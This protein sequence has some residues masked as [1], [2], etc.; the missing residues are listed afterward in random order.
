VQVSPGEAGSRG[1][2]RYLRDPRSPRCARGSSAV[3]SVGVSVSLTRHVHTY[4]QMVLKNYNIDL[5]SVLL[6]PMTRDYFHKYLKRE[7][8]DENLDFYLAATD[9]I[10]SAS[11]R[12]RELVLRRTVAV[13]PLMED[14]A[15]AD[16]EQRSVRSHLPRSVRSHSATHRAYGPRGGTPRPA[17]QRASRTR[18]APQ[19]NISWAIRNPLLLMAN[20]TYTDDEAAVVRLCE[21]ARRGAA[22][23]LTQQA[24]LVRRRSGARWSGCW[25]RR[26]TRSSG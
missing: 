24:A 25:A 26:A 14:A 13:E 9:I 7:F 11:V 17:R 16:G 2:A 18:C 10:G 4:A 15:F 1:Y 5:R 21:G 8:A 19:I 23:L 3:V 22:S 20:A 12:A 6:L